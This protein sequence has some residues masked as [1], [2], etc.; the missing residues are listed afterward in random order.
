ML[1]LLLAFAVTVALG[2]G[3]AWAQEKKPEKKPQRERK[4]VEQ[5]FQE[6]DTNKDGKLS[7]DEFMKDVP[8]ARKAAMEKRFEATDTNKDGSVTSEEMKTARE[9]MKQRREQGGK[10]GK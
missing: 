2:C 5:I 8:E 10:R 6:K 1:R 9:K 4:T 3:A 7:K